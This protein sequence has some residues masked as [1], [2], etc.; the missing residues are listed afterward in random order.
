MMTSIQFRSRHITNETKEA[1]SRRFK[2]LTIENGEACWSWR[3][4][5]DEDGYPRFGMRRG[6]SY[7]GHVIALELRLDRPLNPGK[8][9]CHNCNNS[10]CVNPTHLYEGTWSSNVEDRERSGRTSRGSSHAGSR[11]TE[12][13]VVEIRRRGK[14]ESWTSIAES[15]GLS[16]TCV[17]HAGVGLS[18]T[19]VSE[20]IVKNHPHKRRWRF[21]PSR[22]PHS[23]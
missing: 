20:P 4:G 2:E 9:A 23:P 17:R 21:H 6:T 8:I 22:Q 19:H 11:L 16:V 10:S 13:L 14:I 18:W 15:L 1:I 5:F 3:G 7:S 12:G